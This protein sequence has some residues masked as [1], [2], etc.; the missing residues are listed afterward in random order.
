M[1]CGLCNRPVEFDE[2]DYVKF[3][4]VEPHKNKFYHMNCFGAATHPSR[5]Q[6]DAPLGVASMVRDRKLAPDFFAM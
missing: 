1:I 5:K 4:S 6:S 3:V 2:Q